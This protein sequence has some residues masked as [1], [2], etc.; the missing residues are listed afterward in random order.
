[1]ARSLQ[2]DWRK[3]EQTLYRLHTQE[4][5]HQDRSCLQALWLLRPGRRM[6]QVADL[7]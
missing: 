5:D 6:K 3:D 2:V 1:M 7:T 4:K